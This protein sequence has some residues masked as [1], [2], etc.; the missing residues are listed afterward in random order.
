[1][2]D[3]IKMKSCRVIA[4][5]ILWPVLML[6]LCGVLNLGLLQKGQCGTAYQISGYYLGA[7]PDQLNIKI[8]TDQMLE[9]KD[10]EVEANGVLLFFIKVRGTFRL[11]RIVKEQNIKPDKV[12]SVL[13]DLKSRYGTPDK[14]QIKTSSSRPQNRSRYTTT[15]KNKAIWNISESEEF[16]AEIEST[17]VVYELL[18][19]NPEQSKSRQKGSSDEG[20]LDAEGWDPDY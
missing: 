10:Y 15:V 7:S 8:E 9:E 18:D 12:K 13:D 4:N 17:R 1:M 6:L 2:K 14:Q 16:I 19:H 3:L 20:G 11:Y 5:T